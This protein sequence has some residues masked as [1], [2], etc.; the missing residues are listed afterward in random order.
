VLPR[1][2]RVSDFRTMQL[3]LKSSAN[4]MSMITLPHAGNDRSMV[5]SLR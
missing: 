1:G 3:M 2:I 4:P 5:I